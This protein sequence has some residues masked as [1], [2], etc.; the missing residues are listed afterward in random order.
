MRLRLLTRLFLL[1]LLCG[2]QLPAVGAEVLPLAGEWRFRTDPQ[3]AGVTARWFATALPETVRLPGSMAENGKGDPVSLQTKW[4]ATIY[5]SS[6]FFNPR[7]AKYRQPDNYKVPFWLTPAAYYVGPAWYQKTVTIPPSWRG[8]RVVLLLERAHY[9]TRVWVDDKEV[10]QQTSFVAPHEYDL[11]PLLA[12]G[13]HTLTV[14]VDNRIKE[15][16]VGPDSHS[17]ADHIQ[18]NWNG[19]IG[20]LEL[21]ARPPV[22]LQSLRVYPDV[23]HRTAR[24]QLVVSNTSGKTVKGSAR[25]AAQAFNTATAHQVAP[26]QVAFTAKPG[27]T[28][29]DLTLAMGEAV[30]L[31]DEFHP[32]LYQLTATLQP[33]KGPADE[34]QASFGM[35]EIKVAGRRIVVNGRPVFLRGDLH[36]GEFPLTGY[37]AMDVPAWTRVLQVLKD[38]GFNHI[39]FHSWCPP[40]AA[41]AAADLLGFYLQPEGPSWPNHGTSLGDGRP[42]DK[43]IY[44]ETERM[45]AAYGNHASYCMLAAGNEPAGRNQAKYLGE[46]VKYWQARDARRIYTGASVAMSWPLVPE[47]EYM[48]KSGARGLPWDKAQPNS[49][50]DYRA[51]IE[52]FPMPYVTHEMGQWCVFPDFKEISQYTG[53]YKARNLEMFQQDLIDRGMGEQAEAFLQASGKLQALCYKNEIEATLRTPE[54]AGF[55]LLGLQD[56]P[57]QGTALVG[58]LN[59]FFREKGYLTAAQFRR[60]CQPIVP[61]ARLPKFVFTNNETFEASAELYHYGSQ[62]LPATSLTWTIKNGASVVAQGSFAPATIPTGTNTPLGTVRLPLAAVTKPT[63]LTL[64]IALPGTEVANDWSFWVYPAQ[65]PTLPASDVY[66]CTSLDAKAQQVL[67]RGGRVLLNAAGHV[68]KG[69]EISMNFKPVF[70]N[71]SWFKMKPPHVTGFVV[72]AA[73][74]ALADFPTDTHSDLQWWEIVNQAQVMHLEDFPA[75]FRPIVQPIDTWFLNRRLALVLEARVG[76]GRLLV[77]SANLSPNEDAQ[78][79]AARQLFY[80]LLRYAQS[81]QFQPAAAV[82]LAVVRDLFE[83]PSREQFSTFTKNS[84]DELKP[85]QK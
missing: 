77:S 83:T 29:L 21:L 54:L 6:W 68:V 84:P 65:L 44:D 59:P 2:F 76:K 9:E 3:D 64:E 26:S 85:Q 30:Q 25:V 78:R 40:E 17:I 43:F 28:N 34:Q 73:H 38:H 23:A 53:V 67:A 71:T 60:F 61:L 16:N 1:L 56:F 14:R 70:W 19:L 11:T 48:I 39:R 63:K 18:G 62:N 82:D 22:F 13:A 47:N 42:I 66:Y 41:F 24:V 33:K 20:R 37:P 36:N 57:G 55:Q 15:L 81:A 4:T 79:P 72:N 74:P 69:K 46:F 49:T 45:A 32:A 75:G 5:D 80:S 51:A 10:G 50:F 58:V 7:M 27:T 12:P 52:K 35:R 31:W 8:Q